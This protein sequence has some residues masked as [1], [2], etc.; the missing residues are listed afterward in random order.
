[1]IPLASPSFENGDRERGQRQKVS[2]STGIIGQLALVPFG[3]HWMVKF[4]SS[5]MSL[6]WIFLEITCIHAYMCTDFH[7]FPETSYWVPPAYVLHPLAVCLWLRTSLLEVY[8]HRFYLLSSLCPVGV[9]LNQSP[10]PLKSSLRS[11]LTKGINHHLA[12]SNSG[13]TG[14]SWNGW[15]LG[16]TSFLLLWMPA[17]AQH[18]ILDKELLRF[19]DSGV[20][21]KIR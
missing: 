5:F 2:C 1:M 8:S 10:G 3:F 13:G 14:F 12:S 16:V 6:L 20:S 15:C 21:A 18:V 4:L 11:H 17:K 7:T 9:P 19:L